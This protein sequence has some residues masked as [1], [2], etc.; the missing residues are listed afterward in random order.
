MGVAHFFNIQKEK[1]KFDKI[2]SEEKQISRDKQSPIL[3][4]RLT[5]QLGAL[6]LTLER[7][8]VADR[9]TAQLSSLRWQ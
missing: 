6:A 9:P 3:P 1:C 8:H 2:K 5:K 4:T 7:A